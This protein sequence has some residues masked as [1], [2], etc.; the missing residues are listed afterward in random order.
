MAVLYNISQQ[1]DVVNG[2][3]NLRMQIMQVNRAY[4]FILNEHFSLITKVITMYG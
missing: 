4:Y 1:L 3:L 2:N